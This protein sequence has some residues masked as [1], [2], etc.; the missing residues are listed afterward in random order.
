M[1]VARLR[2]VVAVAPESSG[3]AAD[4]AWALPRAASFL[5]RHPARESAWTERIAE[6]ASLPPSRALL[7]R[8]RADA[9]RLGADARALASADALLSGDALCVTAGQQPGLFLGPL[10][11]VYKAWTAIELAAHLERRTGRRVVPLF[12]SAADDSDFAEI[13]TAVLPEPDLRLMRLSL[14][15]GELPAGGMVGDLSAAGTARALASAEGAL[16]A[17][18]G[19]TSLA[20]RAGAALERARDHGEIAAALLYGLTRDTGLLVVDGRWAELRHAGAA[21]F[22]RYA[23]QR[24][25]VGESVRA[26]GRRL[27]AAGYRA[28]IVDASTEQALFDARDGRRLP[29]EGTEAELLARIAAAPETLSPSVVL[30]PLVQDSVLPNVAT[31]AGPGEVAYHAQ[32]AF[33]YQSLGVGVPILFP[34]FEATL[35]PDGVF[36]LAE[37][38]GVPPVDL[39]RDFD[40]AMKATAAAALPRDLRDALDALEGGLARSAEDTRSAAESLEASL[41]AAAE[42]A[43][44]RCRE[45]VERFRERAAQAVRN[46][47]TRSDP[48]IRHYRELLRPR[49]VPQ[50][51]VLS[52]LTLDLAGAPEGMAE[53]VRR[54]VEGVMEGR[55]AHWLAP[56][57]AE[58][59]RP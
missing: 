58:E 45:A 56:L 26:A 21:L 49:G 6:V 2:G 7:E 3:F 16:G 22:A 33:A 12:W 40:G 15:G 51:R 39:V 57:I 48:S 5:P 42:E 11:A 25:A 18:P 35:V 44:R 41:G 34:R 55:P 54:H 8:A 10:F 52:A 47:D 50:E 1:T 17:W 38:R 4:W 30:R 59:K 46:A 20:A 28:R 23:Q 32:L 36:D 24:A 27:E 43:F 53:A 9:S 37:R 14:E 13:A 19:W 31:V 29:F